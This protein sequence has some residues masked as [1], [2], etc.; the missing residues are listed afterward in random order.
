MK[1]TKTGGITVSVKALPEREGIEFSIQDSG[2][3]IKPEEL[4]KIF[5]AFHQVDASATREFG[6]VGLGLAIVKELIHLL[7]GEIRVESEYGKG[8]AFTVFLPS[9]FERRASL[10]L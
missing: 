2:I 4:P 7:K 3:G 6:G 8:S 5:E 9:H 10:N 1:F